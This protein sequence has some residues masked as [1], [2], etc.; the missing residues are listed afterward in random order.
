MPRQTTGRLGGVGCSVCVC[1]CVCEWGGGVLRLSGESRPVCLL[2]GKWEE[3]PC[4]NH[5]PPGH[6]KQAVDAPLISCSGWCYVIGPGHIK[7]AVDAPL[8][9]C[10]G[11]RSV[12]GPMREV[13]FCE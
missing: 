1:V 13:F 8:I 12:I 5:R 6:I 7:Q 9:S 4:I 2:W 3:W 10:S 11:W